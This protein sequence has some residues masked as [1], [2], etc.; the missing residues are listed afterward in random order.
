MQHQNTTDWYELHTN[1]SFFTYV[2]WSSL[3]DAPAGKHGFASAAGNELYF[4]DHTAARFLGVNLAGAHCFP[5]QDVADK[6]ALQLAAMGCNLVRLHH[7]DAAWA[8]PNIF[9][10]TGSTRSLDSGSMTR[11]DYLIHALKQKGIYL[12]IDLLVHRMFTE[13]D[14]VSQPVEAGGKQAAFFD[15]LLIELQREYAKQFFL[16][17]NTYTGIAYKDDS[18]II[19]TCI[20]NEASVFALYNG[21][22][23]SPQHYELLEQLF[24]VQYPG[25]KLAVFDIDYRFT[26]GGLKVKIP[27]DVSESLSFLT[28]IEAAFYKNIK[29]YLRSIGVKCLISGSNYPRPL[30]TDTFANKD[31]DLI[32]ANNYWDH[33]KVHEVNNDWSRLSEAPV[34]NLSQLR[35]SSKNMIVNLARFA[36]T[37]KPFLVT[38][39]AQ[40]FPNEYRL[41]AFPF[42][43]C[44]G[45]L[46]GWQGLC[47]FDYELSDMH[48]TITAFNLGAMPD[49]LAQWSILAPVFHRQYIKAASSFV[50]EHIDNILLYNVPAYSD[51]TERYSFLPFITRTGK[52]F[53]GASGADRSA[54]ASFVNMTSGEITAETDELV[55]S[56][57]TNTFRMQSPFAQGITGKIAADTAYHFSFFSIELEQASFASILAVSEDDKPLGESNSILLSLVSE[58][59]MTGQQYDLHRKRIVQKGALPML[60]KRIKGKIILNTQVCYQLE[61]FATTG[62]QKE[63]VIDNI[64]FTEGLSTMLVRLVR[65]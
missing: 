13:A 31:N 1:E 17:V 37:D 28:T 30:L 12:Y 16:H 11:L 45:Q 24:A 26:E 14:G 21:D 55:F 59:A 27:G 6:M 32:I 43:V 58:I 54:F 10:N 50:T 41:E 5:T 60:G 7:M 47:Q 23:L 36:L 57:R 34:D 19:G 62:K 56:P 44:Y 9:G 40:P 8:S 46:Q 64:I 51:F 53:S 65:V 22:A 52:T 4:E 33:P 15:P 38:E 20:I 25:K 61:Y 3:L 39:W 35:A 18:A 2:D 49:L 48:K 63:A 42:L 29:E